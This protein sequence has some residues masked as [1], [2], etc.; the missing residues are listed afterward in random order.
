MFV[1]LKPDTKK[2]LQARIDVI[3]KRYLIEQIYNKGNPNLDLKSDL[4]EEYKDKSVEE[5][6][7]ILNKL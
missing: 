5:L 4:K 6:V 2:A 7:E 3:R 1:K